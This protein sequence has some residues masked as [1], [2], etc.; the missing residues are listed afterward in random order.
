MTV[1]PTIRFEARQPRGPVGRVVKLIF[2]L[3]LLV[4][5]VLMLATCAGLPTYVLSDDEEVAGGAILFGAGVLG[6][7]W[8]IWFLGV[9]VMGLLMLLTRGRMMIIEQPVPPRA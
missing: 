2:W 3:V 7:L 9:P 4:P 5:P 6:F 8:S 1:P